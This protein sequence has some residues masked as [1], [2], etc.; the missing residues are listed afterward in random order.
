[1]NLPIGTSSALGKV[2]AF[3]EIEA[4]M[5]Y[6]ANPIQNLRVFCRDDHGELKP[7][8]KVLTISLEIWP[9]FVQG[10]ERLG[11]ELEQRGLLE[12]E[13]QDES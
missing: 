4:E 3:R 7:S 12:K 11:V 10:I 5:E 9:E 6:K 1:M 2:V 8:R 13:D